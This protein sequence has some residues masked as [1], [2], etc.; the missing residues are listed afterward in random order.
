MVAETEVI[1]Y[2]SSQKHVH[3]FITDLATPTKYQTVENTV[4]SRK[5]YP[6]PL[7]T[8]SWC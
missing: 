8:D 5:H 4:D 1:W 6:T 3:P 7:P 2:I